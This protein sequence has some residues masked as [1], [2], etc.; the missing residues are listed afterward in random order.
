MDIDRKMLSMEVS[1]I[2]SG[3]AS[4]SGAVYLYIMK[5][6]TKNWKASYETLV[7]DN[8]VQGRNSSP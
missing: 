2:S 5:K 7:E 1:T 8:Y 6:W 3:V 4:S